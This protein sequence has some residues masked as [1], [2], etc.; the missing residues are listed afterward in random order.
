MFR[1]TNR[2]KTG[3]RSSNDRTPSDVARSTRAT[4]SHASDSRLKY[5]HR[6]QSSEA[7]SAAGVREHDP[8]VDG[9]A[10]RTSVSLELHSQ[11]CEHRKVHRER[12]EGG[13]L[14]PAVEGSIP[15]AS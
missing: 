9:A 7:A 13:M 11:V 6:H 8:V 5:F 12:L 4:L 10:P 14:T 2:Q 15:P 3:G 1:N